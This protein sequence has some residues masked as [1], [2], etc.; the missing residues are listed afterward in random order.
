[1]DMEAIIRAG[2]QI[3]DPKTLGEGS[4]PFAV[5]PN[6]CIVKGLEHLLPLPRRAKAAV[7]AHTAATFDAYFNRFKTPASVI[8]ADRDAFALVGVLDYHAPD[9][10]AFREHH[11]TYT[12]PK[13]KEWTTW[14]GASGKKMP[15]AD[16]AQ[17]IED[18]VIDIHSPPGADV[19]EVA[20]G[21]QAKKSVDFVSAIRLS[22]GSQQFSYSETI[23]GSTAKGSLKV[24]E[25]FTL[26]IPVFFGGDA[27]DV[28]ARL[29]YRIAESKLHLWFDLYRPEYIEQDAFNRVVE[30]SQVATETPIWM[31]KP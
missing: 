31:G 5:V 18:N 21:L 26:G 25:E 13:S 9:Q 16:F 7:A 23:D 4:V 27:Y 8:F 19:L 15:Q 10:A 6:D 2:Q 12:A 1:M 11:V 20:R 30:A 14:R 29:R 3:G 22:D 28:R 24:P 17:F